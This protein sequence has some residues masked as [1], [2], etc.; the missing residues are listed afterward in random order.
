MATE[1][2]N[3]HKLR[4]ALEQEEEELAAQVCQLE[5]FFPWTFNIIRKGYGHTSCWNTTMIKHD[6]L[7][8]FN[9]D[10][11]RDVSTTKCSFS[12][13]DEFHWLDLLGWNRRIWW[14]DRHK[15]AIK[16]LNFWY[17]L[18]TSCEDSCLSGTLVAAIA[19]TIF[20]LATA[21]AFGSF[22]DERLKSFLDTH[23][24]FA[25]ST[26]VLFIIEESI[27]GESRGNRGGEKATCA[28][29]RGNVKKRSL[30]WL[31]SRPVL[32]TNDYTFLLG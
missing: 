8:R 28:A 1:Q 11:E 31:K 32:L 27:G 4:E 20:L 2:D 12:S 9:F 10:V 16:A 25:F 19:K 13:G 7:F 21:R 24:Y 18:L 14:F 5:Q 30:L 3:L 6:R 17:S 23:E 22:S 26:L 15:L 29:E